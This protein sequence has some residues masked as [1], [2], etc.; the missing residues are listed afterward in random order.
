MKRIFALAALALYLGLKC[1]SAGN[2]IFYGILT[3]DT[4]FCQINEGKALEVTFGTIISDRIDGVNYLTDIPWTFT[5]VGPSGL[6]GIDIVTLQYIGTTSFTRDA[7]MSSIDGLGIELQQ[8]GEIFRPGETI[9]FR[10]D[11]PPTL[12][13]VPIKEP[14]KILAEG[15]FEAFAVLV[16]ELQ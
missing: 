14:G 5:C 16:M 6:P 11:S 1:A 12:K 4:P 15:R 3:A 8:N 9:S 13:A 2:L 7:V 10:E